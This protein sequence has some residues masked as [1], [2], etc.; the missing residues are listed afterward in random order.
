MLL[1]HPSSPAPPSC[2]PATGNSVWG[3][4]GDR[5]PLLCALPNPCWCPGGSQTSPAWRWG[6]LFPQV[7]MKLSLTVSAV[8]ATPGACWEEV[9]YS[10]NTMQ[11]WPG[12]LQDLS[13][14]AVGSRGM[15]GSGCSLPSLFLS[16]AVQRRDKVG[17]LVESLK[18]NPHREPVHRF[19][20]VLCP[21][22]PLTNT[23]SD[24]GYI[25]A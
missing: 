7:P 3:E 17:M 16:L 9:G 5:D 20:Q 11:A 23:T 19:P 22:V 2:Q 6:R 12:S 15:H 4:K 25:L 13:G 1:D 24:E 10:Y 21:R 18:T 8:A 14:V